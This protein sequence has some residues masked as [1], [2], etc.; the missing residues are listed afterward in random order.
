MR[1]ER[2]YYYHAKPGDSGIRVYVRK[3]PNGFEFRLWDRE[4]PEVWEK[5]E[6]LDYDT[7]SRAA[8]LYKNERNPN[9]D[10]LGIYDIAIARNLLAGE[11]D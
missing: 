3:G 9:A 6:W 1:D 11:A 4:R 5:H 10:P 7:I 8:S 2:G